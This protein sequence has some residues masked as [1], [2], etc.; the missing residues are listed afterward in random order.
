MSIPGYLYDN[1][2]S[3]AELIASVRL[4]TERTA[5]SQAFDHKQAAWTPRLGGPLTLRVT[6]EG[7]TSLAWIAALYARQDGKVAAPYG[8]E[9]ADGDGHAGP[10]LVEELSESAD[11]ADVRRFRLVL[12][13]AGQVTY[14]PAP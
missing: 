3:P 11:G 5:T 7:I 2:E 10:F 8:V 6:A 12:L 4:T 13:S 14:S 9:L 1:S